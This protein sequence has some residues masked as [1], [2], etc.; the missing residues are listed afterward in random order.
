VGADGYAAQGAVVL[1]GAVVFAVTDGTMNVVIGLTAH[2]ISS[3]LSF[4]AK[5]DAVNAWQ[6]PVC[7]AV[8]LRLNDADSF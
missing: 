7:N 3:P 4:P 8:D 6:F 2:R 5:A 1:I